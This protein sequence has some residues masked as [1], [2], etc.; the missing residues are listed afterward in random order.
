MKTNQ[1]CAI[2][3]NT[4]RK[5]TTTPQNV[6]DNLFDADKATNNQFYK[7]G[8]ELYTIERITELTKQ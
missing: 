3:R 7:Q 5:G 6:P 4:R 8:R 2:Y 1:L